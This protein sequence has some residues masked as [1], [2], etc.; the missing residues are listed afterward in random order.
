MQLRPLVSTWGYE[1]SL[2]LTYKRLGALAGTDVYGATRAGSV[3][4]AALPPRHPPQHW[5]P[6]TPPVRSTP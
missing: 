1:H 6:E 2:V 4:L 3:H 5:L